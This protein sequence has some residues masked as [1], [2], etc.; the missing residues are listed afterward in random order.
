LIQ[1]KHPLEYTNMDKQY[2]NVTCDNG[3][4]TDFINKV[5]DYCVDLLYYIGDITGLSYEVINIILFIVVQPAIIIVLMLYTIH[6]R[7][8]I[9]K[10]NK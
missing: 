1:V 2:N 9:T 5:F 7:N 4:S 8:K 3:C 6:L 10:L